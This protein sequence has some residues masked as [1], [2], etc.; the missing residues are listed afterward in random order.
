[1]ISAA[2]NQPRLG[3]I[4]ILLGMFAIT[5]NDVMIKFL[6]GDY[7]LHQMVFARSAIGILFSFAILQMEGGWRMLLTAQPGLHVLRCVLIVTAN[8]TY[9]TALA[10]MPLA[11]ATALFFVAPLMITLLSIPILGER[12]GPVRMTAVLIGFAGALIMQR[13]WASA[14]ALSVS[15][16][17]LVL[18]LI[19]ALTYA[20]NQLLTRKLGVDSKA[21]AMAIYIQGG[22]V[23]VSLGFYIVA[24]DG[25]FASGVNNPSLVF[26]LR[27]WVWPAPADRWVFLAL[28]VNSAVIGYALTQAYRLADAGT[29]APYEYIGLPLAVLW[30]FVI[31]GELPVATVWIGIVLI[32]SA[33]V[34]VFLRERQLAARSARVDR[35]G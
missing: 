1:M 13:P 15:R 25:R 24:G 32:L 14:D 22:F 9:F 6:S 2:L 10:A 21:S 31:F 12:V 23:V 19:S 11:D 30:G 27:E 4:C 26:L 18:P 35:G 28:G 29:I 3:I 20:L 5:L 17:I 16:I 8:L 34:F 7:P 33:G